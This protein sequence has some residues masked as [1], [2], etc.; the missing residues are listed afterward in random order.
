MHKSTDIKT[1]ASHHEL[2]ISDTCKLHANE[3]FICLLP[4]N[5]I[6]NIFV[7]L[8]GNSNIKMSFRRVDL[9]VVLYLSHSVSKWCYWNRKHLKWNGEPQLLWAL[10]KKIYFRIYNGSSLLII[11]KGHQRSTRPLFFC[12]KQIYL[13]HIPSRFYSICFFFFLLCGLRTNSN[14]ARLLGEFALWWLLRVTFV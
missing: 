11:Y 10:K 7:A 2:V 14:R 9:L 3:A 12:T 6:R 4:L 5:Q 8:M 13:W 1:F